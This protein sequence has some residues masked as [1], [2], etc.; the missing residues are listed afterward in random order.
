MDKEESLLREFWERNVF[1]GYGVS[2][3]E[4][5]NLCIKIRNLAHK[6]GIK[7]SL[8]DA[9]KLAMQF[10]IAIGSWQPEYVLDAAEE[11]LSYIHEEKEALEELKKL[12]KEENLKDVRGRVEALSKEIQLLLAK[13]SRHGFF[14]GAVRDQILRMHRELEEIKEIVSTL[15]KQ[16]R[17][18][19]EELLKPVCPRCGSGDYEILDVIYF[20]ESTSY[21]L[22]CKK[23]GYEY[24]WQ[25]PRGYELHS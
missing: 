11:Y 6:Y 15:S 18:I 16:P 8:I 1:Y 25:V 23:C 12:L 7:I 14:L 5:R 22:K 10:L 13:T 24:A 21:A 3:E 17:D 9:A 19:F 20:K 2:Y 4:F